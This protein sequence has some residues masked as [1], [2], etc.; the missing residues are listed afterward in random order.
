LRLILLEALGRAR[1]VADVPEA[2]LAALLPDGA[3]KKTAPA[4]AVFV[5]GD[6]VQEQV[7]LA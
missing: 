5:G 1:I 6:A 4:G 2:E 3:R 7:I